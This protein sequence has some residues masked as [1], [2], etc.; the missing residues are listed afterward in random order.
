[1]AGPRLL[2][3]GFGSFPG[4]PRNPTERLVDTIGAAPPPG[5]HAHRLDTHW[6]V[7]DRLPPMARRFDAVLMFGVAGRETMIRYERIATAIADPHPD[8]AGDLPPVLARTRY[9]GFD[10]PV[11]VNLARAAG[12][13]V[14]LSHS[15]GTYVCNA[16]FGAA[17]AGNPMSLFVHVPPP[18]R[19]GPLSEAG[20]E[21]HA[22]WLIDLVAA[23]F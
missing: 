8:A 2:V 13:P 1:M 20:L 11:M 17:L 18:T 23:S 3:T 21:A 16:G 15:A 5:V 7:V 6:D 12:F 10:V 9:T 4:M 14:R 22:R 19:R